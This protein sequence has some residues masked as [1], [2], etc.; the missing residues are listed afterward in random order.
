MPSAC[1]YV[2]YAGLKSLG[3]GRARRAFWLTLLAAF[4]LPGLANAGPAPAPAEW[5]GNVGVFNTMTFK[6]ALRGLPQWERVMRRSDKEIE[7]LSTCTP[8]DRGCP[9]AAARWQKLMEELKGQPAMKQ[10]QEVSKF[11]NTWPYRT[12][13][14]IYGVSDYW[15][16]PLEFVRNAGDCED[17]SIVKY[18]ALKR[19]GFNANNMR[20]VALMDRILNI[21]HAILAVY[22]DGQVYVLDNQTN[23]V[24]PDSRFRHY[25]PQY[26]VNE[27][28]KWAHVPARR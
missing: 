6:S 26:S 23:G 7:L 11:F 15:A 9:A 8:G 2:L 1:L 17:Y 21:G 27:F 3:K 22:V 10:L 14:D 28:F 19:L 13:K 4:L 16:T 20:I 25:D 24:Y 12:D 18:Y 5:P